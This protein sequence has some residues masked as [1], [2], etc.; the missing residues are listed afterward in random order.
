M[1]K[2][3]F[4]FTKHRKLKS[5][6][7]KGNLRALQGSLYRIIGTMWVQTVPVTSY[8]F[9]SFKTEGRN[10]STYH[11]VKRKAGQWYQAF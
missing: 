3:P 11:E 1:V 2:A 8:A 5:Y 6:L 10:H 9:A 7:L 4:H